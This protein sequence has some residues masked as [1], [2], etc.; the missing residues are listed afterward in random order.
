MA[1]PYLVLLVC[2]VIEGRKEAHDT[3][4]GRDRKSDSACNCPTGYP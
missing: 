2:V 3:N 4:G 1:T